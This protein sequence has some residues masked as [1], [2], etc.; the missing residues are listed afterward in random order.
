MPYLGLH[1]FLRE[2]KLWITGKSYCV[3]A[4]SR[5]P[6]ISTVNKISTRTHSNWCQC[7]ISGS[8]HFYTILAAY[9]TRTQNWC[10]CPISGS[11]H[12]YL[13]LSIQMTFHS[14]VSM[15]YLGLHSFLPLPS[16]LLDFM[17]VFSSVFAGICQN[18]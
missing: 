14:M 17:R 4:L 9:T 18:I 8:I 15:P 11:I 16:K 1:S 3:N 6:F 12:F 10:Q 7:P 5:A 2:C 13:M